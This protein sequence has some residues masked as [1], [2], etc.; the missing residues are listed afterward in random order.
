MKKVFTILFLLS[1]CVFGAVSSSTFTTVSANA[2]YY[3]STA[4]GT[5]V[6]AKFMDIYID[7]TKG[8]ET[9]LNVTIGWMPDTYETWG[10]SDYFI[11]NERATDET[12]QPVTLK[13]DT[14]GKSFF[15]IK[16]PTNT[17]RM[18]FTT[19]YVSGSTGVLVANAKPEK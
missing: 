17:Q 2:I 4:A 13:F 10:S 19:T 11:V 8:N 7:Y 6:Q 15:Q 16:V 14:T 12:I 9:S 1:V 18:Y 3:I 5:G